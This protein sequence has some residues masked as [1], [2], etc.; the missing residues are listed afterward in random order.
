MLLSPGEDRAT[1]QNT[2]VF[3]LDCE[4]YKNE[5]GDIVNDS[6][7]SKDLV[8]LNQGSELP[9]DADQKFTKFE[10]KQKTAV[11]PVDDDILL[12]RLRP[13]QRI[14]AECHAVK[15]IGATHAK[16]SPVATAFYRLMPSISITGDLT[17]REKKVGRGGDK[18]RVSM[19]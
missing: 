17:D 15:G 16:W 11:R 4:C 8:H 7:Y 6:V 13:G 2:I 14:K 19:S 3:K 10:T 18:R 5:D 12:A 1:Q 9:R